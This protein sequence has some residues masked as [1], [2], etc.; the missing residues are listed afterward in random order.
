MMRP[1]YVVLAVVMLLAACLDGDGPGTSASSTRTAEPTR[2]SPDSSID[3]LQSLGEALYS[4]AEI[5]SAQSLFR[6]ALD[7][8]QQ[9]SD[10]VGIAHALTWLA[11]AG[12]RLG[13]LRDA[14][15]LGEE[16]LDVKLRFGLEEELFDT[17]NILGLI[18]GRE[19]R[20][21]DASDWYELATEVAEATGDSTSL[22][23]VRSNLAEVHTYL[24]DYRAA[25]DG[26]LRARQLARAVGDPR[27]EG[28][29][30]IGLGMLDQEEGSTLTAIDHLE[31]AGPLLA[32]AED[33]LGEQYRVGHL[34]SAYAEIGDLGRAIAL[35][36]NA[37]Q[38]ARAHGVRQDEAS[39]LEL[40]A[41]LNMDAGHLRR[42]LE[43]FSEAK[44]IDVELGLRDELAMDLLAEAEIYQELGNL[45]L[46]RKNAE[47]AL[48]IHREIGARMRE[49]EDLVTRAELSHE[50]GFGEDAR[51]RL[52]E[53][54][55]LA[56]ELDVPAAYLEV[57]LTRARLAEL[58]NDP[59]AVLSAL[60]PVIQDLPRGR[61]SRE[62][63][64]QALRARAHAAQG[65][66]DSAAAV[67]RQAIAAVER[68]R[69]ELASGVL[70]TGYQRQREAVYADLVMVLLRMGEVAEAFEIADA[71]RGR[72][73]VERLASVRDE[74]IGSPGTTGSVANGERLLWRIQDLSR[75]LE[76]L[77]EESIGDESAET[78]ET[79]DRL[80]G[81]LERA[82]AEYSAALVSAAEAAE[83]DPEAAALLGIRSG[84]AVDV[85][86]ALEPGEALLE[87]LLTPDRLLLFVVR[88]D[89]ILHFESEISRDSLASRVRLARGLLG[90]PNLRVEASYAVLMGLYEVLIAPAANEG[91]LAGVAQLMVV[92]HAELN[93][94]P[95]AALGVSPARLE[96]S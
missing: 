58:D 13:D 50:A 66:L 63:E 2:T 65:R 85:Q 16:S 76:E 68:V 25:R 18:A 8:A 22:C 39:N 59:R 60:A 44:K 48:S 57:A 28:R 26:F 73:L 91:A 45:T 54:E 75:Y 53:A 4:A 21:L 89:T 7:L 14:R 95:I 6:V 46:A 43:L 29:A 69:G 86:Q 35:L 78:V 83:R 36:E 42:A 24:G 30:L 72:V 81:E 80:Q 70:R 77:G 74:V 20:L 3:S 62:W 88:A 79:I 56:T 37:L 19:S 61:S 17:Y 34:G 10:S 87:Y 11:K 40:L 9:G 15:R 71:A 38:Q 27:C 41:R 47:E 52:G 1:A 5:D 51:F 31:Q 82:R 92:P 96:T 32:A 55:Q 64:V 67:G 90:Q 84:G 12:W 93:Y 33:P 49:I 23:K 94:L